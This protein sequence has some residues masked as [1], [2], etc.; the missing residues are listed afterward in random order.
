MRTVCRKWRAEALLILALAAPAGAQDLG[1]LAPEYTEVFGEVELE[2]TAFFEGVQFPGQDR[3]DLSIAG[4]ATFLA[5]WEDGDVVLRV[6]PFARYDLV[7]DRRTHADLREAK[8]DLIEGA[9]SFTAGVD[10]VFW[11]KTEAVRLVNIVNQTDSLEDLDEEDLLGQP[12]L[13]VARL[14]DIGEFSAFYFPYFRERPFAGEDGRLRGPI[15]VNTAQPIFETGAEAF[16]P[17]FALRYAGVIDAFDL[18]FH[19]F[20]GLGRDPSFFFDGQILRPVYQRINQIGIDGQ[21]T[22]GAALWKLE[23][24]LRQG[25]RNRRFE[26]EFFGALTGGFEHTLFGI[27]ETN[28]D[29][30]LIG[31]FA[32]DSRGDE[33]LS[34]FESDLIG[35]VRLTLNDPQDTTLLVTS[36]VDVTDAAVGF[37]LEAERR[38]GRQ[39]KIS[40]EANGFVNQDAA[41]LGGA[42]ADDSFVRLKLTYFF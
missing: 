31:E 2:G 20:H 14:T 29:L 42:F 12:L 18:G 6:T 13:K 3:D 8:L 26:E 11:G 28:A 17:S 24:I 15:P 39:F 10:T 5:E 27:F 4:R 33:S 38:L 37:R 32:Y 19:Y 34:T 7:D 9:W 41:S 21:Y 36:S 23:G 16:T 1:A 40:A 22:S 35:G 30:G 25:E